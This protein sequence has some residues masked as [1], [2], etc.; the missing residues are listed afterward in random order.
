MLHAVARITALAASA[1]GATAS[2]ER[3]ITT[4]VHTGLLYVHMYDH[5]ATD[6]QYRAK[7]DPISSSM[8]IQ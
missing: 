6:T 4:T 3:R 5:I 7:P 2:R 1:S 8:Q